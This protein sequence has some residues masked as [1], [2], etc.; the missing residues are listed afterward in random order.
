VTGA[1]DEPRLSRRR[2]LCAVGA[3]VPSVAGCLSFHERVRIAS[4]SLA[5]EQVDEAVTA[6]LRV[7]KDGTERLDESYRLSPEDARSITD[8]WLHDS[9]GRFTL[10]FTA[11]NTDERERRE[12]PNRLGGGCYAVALRVR[13]DDLSVLTA[14]TDSENCQRS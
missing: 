1:D 6:S 8:E 14:H 12:F 9:P 7:L 4:V 5:T 13:D 3:V 2:A 11:S 10:E